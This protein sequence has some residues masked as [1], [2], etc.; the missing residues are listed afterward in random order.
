MSHRTVPV[1]DPCVLKQP[2][3]KGTLYRPWSAP[4]SASAPESQMWS[5]PVSSRILRYGA[6]VTVM[7]NVSMTSLPEAIT[8]RVGIGRGSGGGARCTRQRSR[9]RRE[10]QARRQCRAQSIRDREGR[11]A[12]HSYRQYYIGYRCVLSIGLGRNRRA[13]RERQ[14]IQS[15]RHGCYCCGCIACAIHRY[16]TESIFRAGSQA[17][18][19]RPPHRS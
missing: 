8:G 3:Y 12:T 4:E 7:L 18:E 19:G 5:V 16:D 17:G 2:L 15:S 10:R 9:S 13:R 1:V 14:H 11:V 6:A